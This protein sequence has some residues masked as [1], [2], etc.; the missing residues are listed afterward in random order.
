METFSLLHTHFTTNADQQ[1]LQVMITN[2]YLPCSSILT[3]LVSIHASQCALKKIMPMETERSW[4]TD[5]WKI[6]RYLDICGLSGNKEPWLPVPGTGPQLTVHQG[7]SEA[8]FSVS[9]GPPLFA[10]CP[11]E[12]GDA[13]FLRSRPTASLAGFCLVM[14]NKLYRIYWDVQRNQLSLQYVVHLGWIISCHFSLTRR[15][16]GHDSEQCPQHLLWGL[17]AG[18]AQELCSVG[19]HHDMWPRHL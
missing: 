4:I 2:G 11:A 14:Q 12:L 10:L 1:W 17:R 8:G 6:R 9:D 7:S 15:E 5:K 13:C 16:T 3:Q 19:L 18:A